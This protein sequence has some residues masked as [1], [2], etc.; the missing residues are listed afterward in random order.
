MKKFAIAFFFLAAA[1]ALAQGTLTGSGS[2]TGS[3]TLQSFP[4][5]G[6]GGSGDDAYCGPGDVSSF[7]TFDGPAALPQSCI[8]TNPSASPSPG[9]IH[10]IVTATDLTNC[11][12]H[13]GASCPG[14]AVVCGDILQLQAGNSFSGNFTLPALTCPLTAWVTIETSGVASLPPYGTRVNPSYAGVASQVGRP[15]F[16]CPGGPCANVNVMA[17]I[18]TPNSSQAITYPNNL[19]AFRF[20]GIELTRTPGTGFVNSLADLFLPSG[21]NHVIWDRSWLHGS[22]GDETKRFASLDRS[23]FFAVV[24]SWTGQFQCVAVFGACSDS[25][26]VGGGINSNSADTDHA[27]KIVNN[28]LEASGEKVELGGGPGTITPADLEVRLN[29][30]F[31][32]LTWN[33]LDPS[34]NGGLVVGAHPAEPVIVKNHF[35]TKNSNRVLVEGNYMQNLWSGFSQPGPAILLTPK[36]GTPGSQCPLCLVTN[37]TVRFNWIQTALEFGEFAN[38]PNDSG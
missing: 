13:N 14:G 30:F 17:Q 5:G 3:G 10:T 19:Q 24:D 7:G 21:V 26:V 29:H 1:L 22:D 11:T 4:G 25:H 32:P 6:G 8:Y 35:E 9:T 31:T 36:S 28:F 16:V 12:T 34:Y 23:S 27:W 20:I 33:R 15:A 38:V 2:L 37:T 18:I